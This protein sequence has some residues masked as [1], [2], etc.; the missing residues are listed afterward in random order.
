MDIAKELSEQIAVSPSFVSTIENNNNKTKLSLKI[1]K[2]ICE[3]L[4]VTLS[5]FSIQS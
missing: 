3:V 5:E 4:G 1:L 2:H